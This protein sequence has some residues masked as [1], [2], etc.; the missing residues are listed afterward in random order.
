MDTPQPKPA[1]KLV[2]LAGMHETIK[3]EAGQIIDW[4]PP[5]ESCPE[6]G[7]RG[8]ERSG[9]EFQHQNRCIDCGHIWSPETSYLRIRL[10]E[11]TKH[12]K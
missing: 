10:A 4:W 12:P 2:R 3:A 1:P 9:A 11:P 8:K 6:C 7:K 5:N